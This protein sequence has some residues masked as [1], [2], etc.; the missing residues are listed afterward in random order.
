LRSPALPDGPPLQLAGCTPLAQGGTRKVF[1]HP[2]DP[3]LLVKIVVPNPDR[4]R[5]RL[6]RFFIWLHPPA[7][8]RFVDLEVRA[9]RKLSARGLR[10]EELPLPAMGGFVAT[11][12]GRGQLVEAIFGA[13]GGL[14][15]TLAQLARRGPPDATL[16]EA[17]NR[18][19]ER[20]MTLNI[21]TRDLTVNNIVL[22][23]RAVPPRLVLV[24]GFGDKNTIPLR[25]LSRRINRRKL[26]PS[27]VR[28][29]GRLGLVWT[30]RG[31]SPA[32]ELPP[33]PA[34]P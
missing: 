18:F 9:W 19:A 11:D 32:P 15:P 16:L 22:D 17:L 8:Y 13:D 33:P 10:P 26:V 2:T 6:A 20:L 29:G 23:G 24:D 31:F 7:A 3:G 21:V 27:L 34:R 12:L 14:A 1:R 5:D 30:G 28:L 4:R 25:T